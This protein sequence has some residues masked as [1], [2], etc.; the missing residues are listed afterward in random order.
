MS[1]FPVYL[2]EEDI[3]TYIHRLTTERDEAEKRGY[4]KGLSD[5]QQAIHHP[6]VL[7]AHSRTIDAL[8]AKVDK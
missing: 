4:L 2:I 6:D 8:K 7:W 5:A 1:N 3:G